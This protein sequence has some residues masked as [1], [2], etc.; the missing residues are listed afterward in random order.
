MPATETVVGVIVLP[1]IP[2]VIDVVG[3]GLVIAAVAVH[4]ESE[5]T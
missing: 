2:S 1:Q 5:A 4:R 3:V